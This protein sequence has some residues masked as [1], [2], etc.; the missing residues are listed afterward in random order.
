MPI[1]TDKITETMIVTMV[2][3]MI[4]LRVGQVTLVS[5][6]RISLKN[7]MIFCTTNLHFAGQEGLEP[8]T[9]GFGDRNSTS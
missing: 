9:A 1:K 8:P 7:V 6:A 4:S 5:S 3:P 2:E